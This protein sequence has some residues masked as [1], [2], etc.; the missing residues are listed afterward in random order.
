MLTKEQLTKKIDELN[1]PQTMKN[2]DLLRLQDYN[3]Y[4]KYP[5][6]GTLRQFYFYKKYGFEKCVITMGGRIY[7]KISELLKWFDK[8]ESEV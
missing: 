8:Q 1:I 3:K 4:F 5:S 6:V 2:V 7:I